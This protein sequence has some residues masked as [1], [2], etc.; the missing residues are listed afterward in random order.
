MSGVTLAQLPF[1]YG[2]GEGFE[3]NDT[4]LLSQ[5]QSPYRENEVYPFYASN[6][7][8][9]Y[10]V[11]LVP[12]VWLFGPQYWYGRLFGFLATLITA[13]AIGYAIQRE[14]QHRWVAWLGG[15]AYLA[16]NYI[17]HIGP[18]FRQHISMVM[19]ET[20]AVVVIASMDRIE[21]PQ[22]RRR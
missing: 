20:L 5:G 15:L 17:Y 6:Y 8:P 12:F 10:H 22:H 19:F 9:L 18:L 11:L 4:V 7:P 21:N 13:F 2:Q 3:L 1:D 16:S 14:T